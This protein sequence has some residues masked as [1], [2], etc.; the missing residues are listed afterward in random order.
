MAGEPMLVVVE[1]DDVF[2]KV[3]INNLAGAGFAATHFDGPET[4]MAGVPA[5]ERCDL[6]VLDWRLPGMTG[7]DLLEMLRK[8]GCKAPALLL[9]SHD[10]VFYEEA[11][12]EAG[13]IDF[14]SKTRSFSVLRKRIELILAGQR[15]DGAAPAAVLQRGPLLIEPAIHQAKWNDK[16]VSLTL[17]EFRVTER[18]ARSAG[19]VSYRQLYDVLKG[20]SFIAGSGSE[21][22]RANVRTLVKRIRQKFG[23]VDAAFSAIVSVPGFGYRWTESPTD[24][25]T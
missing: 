19:D 14:I 11:A 3:L 25:Q 2:A 7:V 24:G 15:K 4:A 18:L 10:D 12:L 16:A 22:Y 20:E 21:G 1:D 13:A 5:L 9:T 6:L 23:D 8:Q 17:G